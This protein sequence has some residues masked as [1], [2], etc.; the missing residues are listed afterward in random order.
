MGDRPL[1]STSVRSGSPYKT[2]NSSV[3]SGTGEIVHLNVGGQ[4]FSTSRQ[5]LTAIPDTFFTALLSGRIASQ[6]DGLHGGY[7][8]EGNGADNGAIFIDRDPDLFRPILN[9]LRNRSLSLATPAF[10][11]ENDETSMRALLHEAEYYG[12]SP[13]VK[14]L[15]LCLDL[16]NSGCGDVLFY[17]FLPAPL[18]PSADSTEPITSVTSREP[19]VDP[20]RVQIIKAHQSSIAVAYPYFVAC[21]KQRETVGFQLAFT[22]PNIGSIIDRVAINAKMSSP[23]YSA[24]NGEQMSTMIAVSYG[25]NV[26]LMGFT[27]EGTRLDVGTFNLNAYVD[28]LFFIGTQLV[29][30]STQQQ[31][32][33]ARQQ[34]ISSG[35]KIGVWNSMTQHWQS[36]EFAAPITSYDTAGSLLLL[37]SS[38]GSINYI[39]MQKFPLRMKD[40]DLLVTELYRDPSSQ[41]GTP[42]AITAISVYLTPKTNCVSGNWIEIAYGTSSGAVRVIVHH[43]ETVGHGPQL[44]Q[45]FTVH[46]SPILRVKL[47]E[48]LLV[49]VCSDDNHVRTWSVTR[50]RGMIS[51]QPGSTSISSFKILSLEESH[52][53]HSKNFNSHMQSFSNHR[54]SSYSG[55]IHQSAYGSSRT[56]SNI[57][58][59]FASSSYECGPFG[60]QDDEQVFVQRVIPE[61]DALF[62]RAA[63]NG[64]RVC[65]IR[66]VDGTMV[67]SF[68]VHEC[69]GSSRIGSRPR[70]FIITGHSNG[71]IQMWDLTTAL[72]FFNKSE[73][74]QFQGAQTANKPGPS[75]HGGPTTQEL[76]RMLHC[77]DLTTGN[78]TV[79][80]PCCQLSPASSGSILSTSAINEVGLPSSSQQNRQTLPA[81]NA[82][83]PNGMNQSVFCV[84]GYG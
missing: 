60:E 83:E 78:S 62:V 49:S 16:G 22:S 58:P 27:E 43:P 41:I 26:R 8:N 21:Y 40:N 57:N 36:Q 38:N 11:I 15:S 44:F 9:F 7:T 19:N 1:S 5:T 73:L 81:S 70:R 67:T 35:G 39:D 77:C 12:I 13:L 33:N 45:T 31:N 14:Q 25:S 82:P 23:S 28:K 18:L 6:R 29:A 30:L 46:R 74:Q 75:E 50:F 76:A 71:A 55:L 37:G 53:P 4:R 84:R 66:S 52:E 10:P 64:Q 34:A 24:A 48:K 69:E 80:T 72:D 79:P 2:V 17:G 3:F 68:C 65:I 47:S 51:T 56:L 59:S 63:S 61:T 20:L 42:D 54:L 32:G